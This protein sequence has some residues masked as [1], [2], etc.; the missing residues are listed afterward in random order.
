MDE[1]GDKLLVNANEKYGE[2]F[3]SPLL[4]KDAFPQVFD[5]QS[6]AS[7]IQLLMH[8]ASADQLAAP[9]PATVPPAGSDLAVRLH[10]SFVNNMAAHL[11]GGKKVSSDDGEKQEGDSPNFLEQ[12]KEQ[13]QKKLAAQRKSE[14]KP[15]L[16]ASEPAE[17]QA[18]WQMRFARRNPLSVE[19]RE[20]TVRFVVRGSEFSGLDDQVYERPMSMWA[21]YKVEQNANGGLRLTLLDQGVDPTSVEKGQRFVAADAPLRSKLR[22]RWKETLEGVDG[23]NKVI[24]VFPFELPV[25]K[26]KQV[27]PLAYERL[28]LKEGWLTLGM[29]RTAGQVE[30]QA[31]V[32]R[33]P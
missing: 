1:E 4:R 3:R 14:G 24:E 10:E 21:K 29:R 33:S 26:F 23:E 12:F 19:F 20:G 11:L 30:R 28:D 16:P 18:P 13:R 27:G 2:K 6:D 32:E 7:Q 9:V 17:E 15:P 22:V 31:A 8:E 25:P 5:V